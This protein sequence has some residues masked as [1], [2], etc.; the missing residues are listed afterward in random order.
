M[1]LSHARTKF[2]VVNVLAA[3]PQQQ[4]AWC[5]DGVIRPHFVRVLCALLLQT[6]AASTSQTECHTRGPSELVQVASTSSGSPWKYSQ[7][8]GHPHGVGWLDVL[9]QTFRTKK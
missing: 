7:T 1:A 5:D 8:N 3:S 2:L 4:K 9:S 6:N